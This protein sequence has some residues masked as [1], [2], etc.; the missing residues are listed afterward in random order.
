[1]QDIALGVLG[2]LVGIFL[3]AR[4]QWAMRVIITV[5]G[6]FVGFATG[7]G[8]VAAILDGGSLLASAT[9]WTLG[10]VLAVVFAVLAYL[11]YAVAVVIAFASMGFVIGATVMQA[12]GIDWTWLYSLVGLVLGVFFAIWA[13]VANLP[14]MLLIV[15]SSSAGAAVA[16]AGTMLILGVIEVGDFSEGIKVGIQDYL[17]WWIGYIVLFFAGIAIQYRDALKN[18]AEM[19]DAWAKAVPPAPTA[20]P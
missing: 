10:F 2:L 11:Y 6:A 13:I 5:W 17:F 1:M 8:I 20:A 3:V 9:G 18:Q 19:R 14:H 16:V 15:L 7:A 12:I 4:G